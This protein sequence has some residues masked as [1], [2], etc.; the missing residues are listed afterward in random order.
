ME[1]QLDIAI[2]GPGRLGRTLAILLERAGHAV[3]LVHRGAP[4]PRD[5]V[6]LLT[7]PDRDIAGVA[8]QAPRGGPLLHCSGALSHEVLRPHA[9]AGSLHPLMTF[10]G[11]DHPL[12]ALEG[13]PAAVAG[14]PEAVTIAQQIASDLSLRPFSVPGDR[15]L[16]HAAAVIAGNFA[17]ALVAEAARVMARAGVPED[18]ARE[19]LQPL[20]SRSVANA[21][22]P[23]REVLT[24]PLA[25]GDNDVLHS[26]VEALRAHGM[27]D[28]A[29]LYELLTELARLHLVGGEAEKGGGG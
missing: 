8:Q 27:E 20:A 9:P 4:I 26:H 22:R 7:V 24:G 16:Y 17:T 3:T 23:L 19:I 14:D 5:G 1:G 6:R 15:R 2:V 28:Q 13:V 18:E 29:A 12:P 21:R 25:R 11:P 10:P